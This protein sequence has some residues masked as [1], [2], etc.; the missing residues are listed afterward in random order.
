MSLSTFVSCQD[1]FLSVG[2]G[3]Y[4]LKDLCLV[5]DCAT[6]TLVPHTLLKHTMEAVPKS[7]RVPGGRGDTG[8]SLGLKLTFHLGSDLQTLLKPRWLWK[9]TDTAN[10][11]WP[12]TCSPFLLPCAW[13]TQFQGLCSLAEHPARSLI[14]RPCSG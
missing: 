4:N 6:H 14:L 9:F 3:F 7:R 12:Y 10:A 5:C 8:D 1:V 11:C 2:F 13:H